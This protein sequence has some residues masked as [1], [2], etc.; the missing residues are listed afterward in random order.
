MTLFSDALSD[1]LQDT[2]MRTA[3]TFGAATIYGVFSRPYAERNG[4]ETRVPTFE[5]LDTDL[6]GVDHADTI[7]I[8]AVVYN[9]IEIQPN[10]E[11]STL[12]ILGVS[13]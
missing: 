10:G 11:G 12:L 5:A 13:S 2:G 6:S 4:V 8:N 3:A 9:I 7:T 1:I